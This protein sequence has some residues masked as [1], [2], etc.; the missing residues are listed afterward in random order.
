MFTDYANPL[1]HTRVAHGEMIVNHHDIEPFLSDFSI[2]REA[3]TL[4]D[5][6]FF[7]EVESLLKADPPVA[8]NAAPDREN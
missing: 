4:V 8:L 5:K 3:A 2:L 7:D 6:D 1:D